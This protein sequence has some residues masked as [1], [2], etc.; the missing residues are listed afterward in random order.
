MFFLVVFVVERMTIMI[1]STDRIQCT[2]CGKDLT[3]LSS[4]DC[5]AHQHIHIKEDIVNKYPKFHAMVLKIEKEFG[6][7]LRIDFN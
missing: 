3:D 7:T 4:K 1:K 2:K 6:I 5:Q